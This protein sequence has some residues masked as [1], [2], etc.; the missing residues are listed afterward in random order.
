MTL[1]AN[2][3]FKNSSKKISSQQELSLSFLIFW[4]HGK[5]KSL[6]EWIME[7]MQVSRPWGISD[8]RTSCLWRYLKRKGDYLWYFGKFRVSGDKK[9]HNS[10][11]SSSCCACCAK[12]PSIITWKSNH[13]SNGFMIVGWAVQEVVAGNWK[14]GPS[15]FGH[16]SRWSFVSQW[17]VF[18]VWQRFSWLDFS[19]LP[20]TRFF[21]P[22]IS[23]LQ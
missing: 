18:L 15:R 3:W 19:G 13:W 4:S 14:R 8:S 12:F 10:S 9:L 2:D 22:R 11:R 16:L 5:D 1:C 17:N 23:M 20:W 21:W 6:E 7:P